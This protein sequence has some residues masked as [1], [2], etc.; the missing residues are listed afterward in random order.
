MNFDFVT[1]LESVSRLVVE[2]GLYSTTG[3]HLKCTKFAGLLQILNGLSFIT[4]LEQN[5][6]NFHSLMQFYLLHWLLQV[7]CA[8]Q[9][10]F[11]SPA[12][13]Y[14]ALSK[15]FRIPSSK[16]NFFSAD[17]ECKKINFKFARV[18]TTSEWEAV[19]TVMRNTKRDD[20]WLALKKQRSFLTDNK[21]ASAK[22]SRC[23]IITSENLASVNWTIG[24]PEVKDFPIPFAEWQWSSCYENC[25]RVVLNLAHLRDSKCS[26]TKKHVLCEGNEE[27]SETCFVI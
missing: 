10:V 21:I 20:V 3:T 8:F 16:V 18:E 6:F 5:N 25:L 4:H 2:A 12:G 11:F 19:K 9:T 24:A 22:S 14:Q 1:R 13:I 23:D 7:T 26:D 17:K 15:N 27:N